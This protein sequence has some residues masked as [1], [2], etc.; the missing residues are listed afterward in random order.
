MIKLPYRNHY[1]TSAY[2]YYYL[3]RINPFTNDMIKFQSNN[4]DVPDRQYTVTKQTIFLCKRI[5]NNR[6][7]NF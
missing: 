2:I 7:K 4:F 5:N 1:S 3:M 6:E